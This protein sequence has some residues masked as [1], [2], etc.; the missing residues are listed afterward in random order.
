MNEE[1]SNR[2]K[3]S[4]AASRIFIKRGFTGAAMSSISESCGISIESIKQEFENKEAILLYII[5]QLQISLHNHV[6]SIADDPEMTQ[7]AKLEK[8]NNLLKEYFLDNKGCLVAMVGM[9]TDDLSSETTGILSG[10]F[11][12]WKDTYKKLFKEHHSEPKAEQLAENAIVFIEGAIV[13]L[14]V[15]GEEKNL[16]RAFDDIN[17]FLPEP[18]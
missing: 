4:L 2:D 13:W 16:L 1:L 9:S 5:K 14:R 7:S 15:T 3:I 6:F 18:E 17:G 11:H 10:I 12:D 8:M